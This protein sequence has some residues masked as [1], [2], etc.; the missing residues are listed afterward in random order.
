MP[1]PADYFPRLEVGSYV[2]PAN[3]MLDRVEL[4]LRGWHLACRTDETLE[5]LSAM[6]HEIVPSADGYANLFQVRTFNERRTQHQLVIAGSGRGEA[7]TYP[8][9]TFSGIVN[10]RAGEQPHFIQLNSGSIDLTAMLQL[11]VTRS[12]VAQRITRP[13]LGR[14]P[15]RLGDFLLAVAPQADWS[16]EERVF[17]NTDNVILGARRR[18]DFAFSHPPERHLAEQI[19][20]VW[21]T[22]GQAFE[23]AGGQWHR[24]THPSVTLDQ[25]EVYWEFADR[26]PLHTLGQL[27]LHLPRAA[28]RLGVSRR[29]LDKTKEEKHGPSECIGLTLRQGVFL[30]AYAK[31]DWRLRFEICFSAPALGKPKPQNLTTDTLQQYVASLREQA[32]ETLNNVLGTL[33]TLS[34]LS[35]A[36]A[37]TE[38]LERSISARFPNPMRAAAVLVELCHWGHIRPRPRDHLV[39]PGLAALV[40]DGVLARDPG[41]PGRRSF[42]VTPSYELAR[43][44]LST[45]P[46]R[47]PIKPKPTRMRDG[48]SVKP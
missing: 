43:R 5:I 34:D 40:R 13:K 20:A 42:V 1:L 8:Y 33:W 48:D 23:E 14:R 7:P 47:P 26:S 24:V 32:A 41:S 4:T 22:I 21:R 25:I 3:A 29:Y 2:D 37:T 18:A 46:S 12:L 9:P 17:V 30:R 6:S 19:N 31:S 28:E 45:R 35:G 10:A 39:R 27:R 44:L 11:N 16:T 15:T 36:Q 38:E